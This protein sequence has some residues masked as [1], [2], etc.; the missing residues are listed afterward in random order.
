M[1]EYSEVRQQ[2][3]EQQRLPMNRFIDL[4]YFLVGITLTILALRWLSIKYA[5]YIFLVNVPTLIII[6]LV[7]FVIWDRLMEQ[8]G[9][10]VNSYDLSLDSLPIIDEIEPSKEKIK[11]ANYYHKGKPMMIWYKGEEIPH[12]ALQM[13]AGLELAEFFETIQKLQIENVQLQ[14]YVGL[15]IS[16]YLDVHEELRNDQSLEAVKEVVKHY[17]SISEENKN[18]NQVP[19]DQFSSSGTLETNQS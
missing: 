17:R 7:G 1:T 5:Q 4:I 8:F 16:G 12:Q 9:V 14:E 2:E 15:V 10:F 13:V 6:T 18:D 11:R 3:M 19:T